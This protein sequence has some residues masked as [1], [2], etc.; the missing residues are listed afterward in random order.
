MIN[1]MSDILEE[2][3]D[4]LHVD[5]LQPM[6]SAMLDILIDITQA[7][8][9]IIFLE[10]SKRL[11]VSLARNHKRADIDAASIAFS[12]SVIEEALSSMDVVKTENAVTDKRFANVQSIQELRLLSILVIPFQLEEGER[13]AV[14]LDD[15]RHTG[16][17]RSNSGVK[18]K[19]Y[20]DKI[21]GAIRRGRRLQEVERRNRILERDAT[22]EFPFR[23][24]RGT[25]S[26]FRDTLRNLAKVAPTDLPVLITGPHGSGKELIATAVHENSKRK[27]HSFVAINCAAIP[28]HLIEAQLF[29]HKKGAF[30]GATADHPGF[31]QRANEGTLFLDEIGELTFD[32]QAKLLRAIQFGEIQAVGAAQP[33]KVDVRIVA[34][35]NKNLRRLIEEKQFREDLFYRLDVC[36]IAVPTLA[37]R[38]EDILPIAEFILE[39]VA[40]NLSRQALRLAPGAK[41][42]LAQYKFPGNIREL[43]NILAKAALASETDTISAS[44][45]PL[46]VLDLQVSTD[47]VPSTYEGLKQAKEKVQNDIEK[48]FLRK[49]LSKTKGNVSQAAELAG[50]HRVQLQRMIAKVGKENI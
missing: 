29:G 10:E 38:S 45:L 23:G 3:L 33:K 17:F 34:A 44:D 14:Y 11:E 22:D 32:L 40:Q 19:H 7:Q 2:I 42:A 4:F 48:Q 5:G 46:P 50:I 24:I 39:E 21:V 37:E 20:V 36:R 12:T 43:E 1:N 28:D 49:L 30:T 26:V 8:R 18:T 16:V 25:S 31:F 47:V 6:L 13:G 9:G 35:T 27:H 15:D 41:E